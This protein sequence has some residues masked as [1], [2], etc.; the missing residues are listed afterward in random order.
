VRD[1][2]RRVNETSLGQNRFVLKANGIAIVVNV[3]VAKS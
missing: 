2:K 1:E 3:K